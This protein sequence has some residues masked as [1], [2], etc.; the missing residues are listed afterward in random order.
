MY[1]LRLV[2]MPIEKRIDEF[3]KIIN[4]HKTDFIK[5]ERN[6]DGFIAIYP[7]WVLGFAYEDDLRQA[8]AQKF[9][10]STAIDESKNAESAD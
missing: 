1:L 7:E 8:V 4:F 10:Q 6:L 9:K 3:I 5:Y 2:D